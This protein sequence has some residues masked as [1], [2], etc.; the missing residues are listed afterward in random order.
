[1]IETQLF[2]PFVPP[3]A[4]YL[5]L[6]GFTAAPKNNDQTYDWYYCSKRNQF[7]SI[8]EGVYQIELTNT[9]QKK[10]LFTDLGI[11]MADSILQCERKDGNS[12]DSNLANST[13][14]NE[15]I[16]VILEEN[17]LERIL[18]T[19]RFAEKIY[20]K[21]FKEL[22]EEFSNIDL[23]TLLSSSPRYARMSKEEKTAKYRELL[24][25]TRS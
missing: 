3:N 16:R 7:W 8:I 15:K 20:R 25:K 13:Y 21:H 17:D 24:P 4:K 23:V 2:E 18:F 14:N 22:I 9:A 10:K 1:M 19:S 6:G 5:L 12:S 11:A